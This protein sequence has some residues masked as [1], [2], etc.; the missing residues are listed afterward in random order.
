[1]ALK[2][3]QGIEDSLTVLSTAI[4][5]ASGLLQGLSIDH[6]SKQIGIAS[7]TKW[8]AYGAEYP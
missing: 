6:M 8:R 3:E 4:S 2:L 5:K 7:P 1:M